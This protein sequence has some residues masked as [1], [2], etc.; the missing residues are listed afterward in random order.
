MKV[1][2]IESLFH[3]GGERGLRPEARAAIAR[4]DVIIGVDSATQN[5]FTVYGTPAFEESVPI[6]K[7]VALRT[8]RIGFS[9]QAGELEKVVAIVRAIKRGQDYTGEAT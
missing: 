7:E 1:T 3:D 6:G 9:E 5:E 2:P 8:V 4:A